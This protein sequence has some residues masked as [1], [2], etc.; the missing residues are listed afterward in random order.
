MLF[1][2]DTVC[3]D[4]HLYVGSFFDTES[5]VTLQYQSEPDF[6]FTTK[7]ELPDET[8]THEHGNNRKKNKWR[9]LSLGVAGFCGGQSAHPAEPAALD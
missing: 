1:W 7:K 2:K 5:G 4:I 6:T 8:E 9:H 3:A